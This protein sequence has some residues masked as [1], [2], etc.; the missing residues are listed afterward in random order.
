MCSLSAEWRKGDARLCTGISIGE[1]I[2]SGKACLINSDR[3]IHKLSEASIL[4]S[5]DAN[6][7]WVSHLKENGLKALVTDF[8][9]RNSHAAILCRELGVPGVVG[10][11]NATE[12]LKEGQQIT[13]QSI[14]GDYGHVYSGAVDCIETRYHLQDLPHTDTAVMINVASDSAA[15]QWWRLPCRG[16][17]LVRMDYILQN[18]IKV[19][20]MALARFE[21][22]AEN[23]TK[24]RI[25]TLTQGYADKKKYFI[26]R[27]SACLSKIA[28]SRAPRPVIVRTNN[29]EPAEFEKLIGGEVFEKTVLEGE[30][31]FQG[32]SRYRSELY[33]EAFEMECEAIR[34]V[35]EDMGF[36]NLHL[37][38]PHCEYLREAREIL[39]I[40]AGSRIRRGDKGLKIYLCC[41]FASNLALAEDF[42]GLFDGFSL[43]IRKLSKWIQAGESV[44]KDRFSAGSAVDI[45]LQK[46]L[47]HLLEA[48]HGQAGSLMVR[49]RLFVDAASLIALLVDVGVDAI[50]ANPEAIPRVMEWIANAEKV[51]G[52][53]Y[54]KSE[55]FEI[56][57]PTKGGK[58][59]N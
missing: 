13:V 28:A 18:I 32:V 16:I 50:S 48:C 56:Y 10:T 11:H 15:Y 12:I 14:E 57:Q 2:A 24:Y 21:T 47:E 58:K 37:M 59:W 7:A 29:L 27:L 52:I 44:L 9:G 3:E 5:E 20:P 30:S 49:G 1:G 22:M 26:D 34:H 53:G 31:G 42:A 51:K 54:R 17:G 33:R 55:N 19:H 40:L 38:I 41:D 46:A 43:D 36:T 25:E 8:G 4:V 23:G 6:T 39:E 45:S 35:R